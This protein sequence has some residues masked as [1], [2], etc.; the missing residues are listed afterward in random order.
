MAGK[1]TLAVI[2]Q[3]LGLAL[4][5]IRLA[6]S[7]PDS[8]S[9]FM[10]ELGWDAD[11]PIAA[12]QN[13]GA[14]VEDVSRLAHNGV[15]ASEA[16]RAI[17][18]V[19]AFFTA[20]SQLSSA[21]GLPPTIDP[22]EFAAD[23]AKQLADYLVADY[24]LT[25]HP[26]VGAALLAAGVIRRTLKPAAGKR[27]S[28]LRLDVAW[29]DLG[30]V[31]KDPFSVFTN[32]Y[33]WGG[34]GF[35]Q[36]LFLRNMESLG[37]ALGAVVHSAAVG[38][39]I[40]T[41]LTQGA[42]ATTRL[43]DFAL[44]W[45]VI[46]N[47]TN[48][49]DL[50]AGLDLYPLPPTAAAAPGIAILPFVKGAAAPTIALGD[51]LSLILKAA[52]DLAGGV[53]VSIRPGQPVTLATGVLTPSPGSAAAFSLVLDNRDS[54]GAKQLLLGT[55]GASRFEYASLA[56]TV[57]FRTDSQASSFF[58]EIALSDAAL[59]I[60]SGQDADG[61]LATLLPDKMAVDASLTL[62][63]DS[64]LG[65]YFSGSAGLEI[66]IPAHISLGPIEIMS[67]TISVKPA[68]GAIPI[69]LGATLQGNL[70][71]LQAVVENVGLRIPLTFPAHGGNL[72]PVNA[73]L[74]FKPPTGVGL[75]INA[76]VVTGGGF[77]SFDPDRGEYAGALQLGIANFLTV[78]AIGL[79][80]TRMPDGSR[81]FSLL[82]IITAD[83]GAGIQLSFGFT[84]LAVGG[85]LGLNRTVL[86][87]PLM[88]GVKSGAI[89]SVMFPQNVIANAP[90]IISDL[91]ALFPPQD[92]TFL[93][94]PMAK[95]GWG[96]PTLI[97]LSLGVIIEIPPG[98]AA[99]LGILK[100]A[101]P[102]DELPIL[103][104]QVNFAGALE[105]DKQRFYFFASLFDSHVLFIT[106]TGD[107]GVLF[108][109]GDNANFVLS[110]GG[111]HPQF[112]PPP[113][114]FPAPQR[115]AIDLINE[116][117]AK[118]HS[119]GYFAVTTN[120]IQFGAHSSFFFGFSA[121]SVQGSSGFD[122]LI[123]F[124]PFHFIAEISTQFSVKVFGVGVYGVGIDVSLEGPTPWHVH[125]TASLSFFFFSIDIGIDFTWGD[126][127]NTTLPPIA[128]MPLLEAEFKKNTNWRA[129]LPSSSRLLVTLRQL[130]PSETAMVLHPAGT[131]QVSQRTIPLDLHL[132]KVGSQK[133]SDADQF[134]LN[135]GGTTLV[136]TRTLTEPFA[137][138]QFRNFDD[139]TKLSQP[140]FAPQDSGIELAGGRALASAT[141]VTRP[142][143]YDLT[144]IDKASEPV[145]SKFFPHTRAMFGAFLRAN[146]AAQSP[147]S[148]AH[149]AKTKP[150]AD[151]VAVANETFAV[152]LQSSNKAVHASAGSFTSQASAQ[153]YLNKLVADDPSLG[154][155][156]HV[157]PSFEVA[158]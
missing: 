24:L 140:A 109:Y 31:F 133:P 37:R 112:N 66:Q 100:I 49:V 4:Q 127:P 88:D 105:F 53:I 3:E 23:F 99:I 51:T 81:G 63:L 42:T 125:G 67:A 15:D 1:D 27:P 70:G 14:I 38:G 36:T 78:S 151:A 129:Q 30:N 141:A 45:Q 94:G 134:S 17:A 102:A 6:V 120:T 48:D 65:V 145:R 108:A 34:A 130:D 41:A 138:S 74:Q 28:Y 131:L 9:T 122:A 95:I 147:L 115:I 153:D 98:N 143:R 46:D 85:L 11:A 121:C 114:P 19:A 152:A 7:D 43:Q 137:P 16:P 104:L 156:L 146:S 96:T 113:L 13:L 69:E 110:V 18:Q 157:L 20:V 103:V 12:I 154:G 21:S 75:S 144:V 40:E 72:G 62:G 132:D 139:A 25:N 26:R 44:R 107:M 84:L 92:G 59:V 76:G 73:A 68:S 149:R 32:A 123:Q 89:Q 135:V 8:F 79:I 35:D 148:A 47:P 116:S 61:F 150:Y 5:P 124:S 90:R 86:F 55:E 39:A 82:I 158:A 64:R 50:L 33:G 128:V 83:F 54:S 58:A 142:V 97:S 119:D 56:V 2:A 136:K 118:I 111:F 80:S 126:N 29:N 77:L 52:F 22:A 155:S 10:L 91:R 57:G 71:P 93:I 106:I 101:L 117:F 60:A 87:Q